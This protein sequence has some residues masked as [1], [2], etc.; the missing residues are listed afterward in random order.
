MTKI[1]K[2]ELVQLA[3]TFNDNAQQALEDLGEEVFEFL[4]VLQERLSLRDEEYTETLNTLTE[5]I[6]DYRGKS[7]RF[8]KNDRKQF[9]KIY[10][11][12][13]LMAA[14]Q[15]AKVILIA[16]TGDDSV[17]SEVDLQKISSCDVDRAVVSSAFKQQGYSHLAK[18][19]KPAP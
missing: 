1:K 6:E 4:G 5:F 2:S 10:A 19:Y 13:V 14:D 15:M 17:L 18:I 3:V 11:L 7:Q 16:G 8:N 9:D 12:S